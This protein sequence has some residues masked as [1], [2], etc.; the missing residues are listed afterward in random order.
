MSE[1]NGGLDALGTAM[2]VSSLGG[3]GAALLLTPPPQPAK[4]A[5]ATS[6]TVI[7]G[8]F[9]ELYPFVLTACRSQ[10]IDL[11]TG[12]CSSYSLIDAGRHPTVIARHRTAGIRRGPTG[13]RSRSTLSATTPGRRA[14]P[15]RPHPTV[16]R[17]R[18]SAVAVDYLSE[19][20]LRW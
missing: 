9:I 6:N 18:R 16:D 3:V 1:L 17:Q 20:R 7:N 13:W 2:L 4:A 8:Y 15:T 11:T 5:A 14:S 19:S 10:G 12:I